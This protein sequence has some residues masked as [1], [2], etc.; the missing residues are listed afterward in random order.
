ME[1]P[2]IVFMFV[3][4]TIASVAGGTAGVLSLLHGQ[5]AGLFGLVFPFFGVGMVLFSF[6]PEARTAEAILRALYA[7]APALPAPPETGEAYR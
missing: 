6:P 7:A 4:L 3:W 5:V 1:A 2:V